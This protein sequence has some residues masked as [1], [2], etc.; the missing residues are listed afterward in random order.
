MIFEVVD[1]DENGLIDRR[2][3]KNLFQ[4]Y[5]LPVVYSDSTFTQLDSDE[6]G[7]LSRQEILSLLQEFYFSDEPSALGNYMFGPF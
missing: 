5:N 3:W 1:L 4:V 2:E 6:D 7:F